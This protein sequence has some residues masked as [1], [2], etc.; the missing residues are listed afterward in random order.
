MDNKVGS[1]YLNSSVIFCNL[2]HTKTDTTLLLVMFVHTC[3]RGNPWPKDISEV[4]TRKITWDCL[5]PHLRRRSNIWAGYYEH[6]LPHYSSIVNRQFGFQYFRVYCHKQIFFL[7]NFI[8]LKRLSG[9]WTFLLFSV[10][11]RSRIEYNLFL[12]RL[13]YLQDLRGNPH[14]DYLGR[15]SR[16]FFLKKGVDEKWISG[17]F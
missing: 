3:S 7:C 13:E 16:S 15:I 5:H 17:R 6:I 12:S 11:M 9:R 10:W 8:I 2:I 1:C 4:I 14:R